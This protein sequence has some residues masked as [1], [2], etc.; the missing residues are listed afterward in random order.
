VYVGTSR[1]DSRRSGVGLAPGPQALPM[2]ATALILYIK[3]ALKSKARS[4]FPKGLSLTSPCGD[5]RAL[6]RYPLCTQRPSIAMPAPGQMPRSILGLT[7]DIS[8]HGLTPSPIS[9]SKVDNSASG[10]LGGSG[11]YTQTAGRF[12][13][14]KWKSWAK[15]GEDD[16]I[17]PPSICQ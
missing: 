5:H 13:P 2:P 9:T 7:S 14:P 17:H 11:E 10:C 15:S 4:S 6:S 8:P 12:S 1:A 16:Q 3:E